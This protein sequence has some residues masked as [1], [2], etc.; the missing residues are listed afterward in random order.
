MPI[1]QP[2]IRKGS[3]GLKDE[4][5]FIVV[6]GKEFQL[7]KGWDPSTAIQTVHCEIPCSHIKKLF[8]P[9]TRIEAHYNEEPNCYAQMQLLSSQVGLKATWNKIGGNLIWRRVHEHDDPLPFCLR[10]DP[11][12]TD[13]TSSKQGP[14]CAS[15][16]S[17]SK[18]NKKQTEASA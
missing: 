15:F 6:N 4:F 10:S 7:P 18:K 1:A 8:L 2:K 17:N 16:N 12:T 3:V 11:T 9:V 5:K 14:V 13:S